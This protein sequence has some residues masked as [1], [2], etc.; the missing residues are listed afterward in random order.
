M[1]AFRAFT[2]PAE[3]F[4]VFEGKTAGQTLAGI[5]LQPVTIGADGAGYMLKV[6]K[7]LLFPYGEDVGDIFGIKGSFLE[8]FCQILPYGTQSFRLSESVTT[9]LFMI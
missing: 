6:G 5:Y 7:D 1:A 8:K 3:P 9:D 4:A 2:G